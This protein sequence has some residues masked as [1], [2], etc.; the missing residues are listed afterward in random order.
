[1][2]S[3]ASLDNRTFVANVHVI[4]YR[5]TPVAPCFTVPF[6]VLIVVDEKFYIASSG[7]QGEGHFSASE[8]ILRPYPS[9]IGSTTSVRGKYATIADRCRLIRD[10]F[11]V[12][13]SNVSV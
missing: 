4:G 8:K 2:S 7:G 1:M 10:G 9:V 11:G 13:K 6:T 12:N 5:S 3:M